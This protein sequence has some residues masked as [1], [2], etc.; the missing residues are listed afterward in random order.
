MGVFVDDLILVV[1]V[2]V[3]ALCAGYLG[4]CPIC[5]AAF[6]AAQQS[7]KAF[8]ALLDRLHLEQS[9]KRIPMAQLGV[10]L[11]IHI[12]TH[13]G[14]YTLTEKKVAKL[15]R[16]LEEVLG[17]VVM[18][19]RECSKVRGKL[20]NYSFCMQRIKPFIQPF[21]AFIGG[22]RNNR[23]WDAPKHIT[24]EMMDVAAFLLRHLAKLV[25]LGSPIWPTR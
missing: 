11:G 13:Q 6:P 3:H 17:V 1:A 5:A 19:P 18:T 14:L 24:A 16:D 10:Y 15:V 25:Q 4:G 22:P 7:Q 21:N 8:E 9:D 2:I 12:D 23:E 20:A